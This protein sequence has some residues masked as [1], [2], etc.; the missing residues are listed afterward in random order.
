MRQQN[1]GVCR[2]T[3]ASTEAAKEEGGKAA[4]GGEAKETSG[5][6][7][8]AIF[9]GAINDGNWNETQY[10]GLK[11]I[12][13]AGAEIAYMENISDTDAAEAARTYASEGFNL[14]YLTT[15]SYQDYCT[16]V[17][18][19]LPGYNLCADQRNHRRRQLYF[20]PHRR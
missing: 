8:A 13:E 10:N 7:V 18:K 2:Q 11:S 5:L 16:P 14:V 6:K 17:C 12:E 3:Q 1:R 15:N 19:G 4:E 9:G 20:C